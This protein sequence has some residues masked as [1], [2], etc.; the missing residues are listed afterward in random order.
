M[1]MKDRLEQIEARYEQ[2]QRELMNPNI[3]DNIEH[4][5]DLSKEQSSL[6]ETV[7]LFREYKEI[8]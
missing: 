8:E 3:V 1:K 7:T 4:M 2:I 6:E 5:T